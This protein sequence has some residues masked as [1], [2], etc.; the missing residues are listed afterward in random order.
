MRMAEEHWTFSNGI[1]ELDAYLD[2][3]AEELRSP[4]RPQ[5]P[6]AAGR[7]RRD[8][9]RRGRRAGFGPVTPG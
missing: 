9:A 2:R 1:G 7:A 8:R 4:P 6:R 3:L 5:A